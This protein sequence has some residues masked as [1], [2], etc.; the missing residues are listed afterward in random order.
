[1]PNPFFYNDAVYAIL[2]EINLGQH[3][4]FIEIDGISHFRKTVAKKCTTWKEKLSQRN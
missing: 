4:E 2:G 1:L 3:C